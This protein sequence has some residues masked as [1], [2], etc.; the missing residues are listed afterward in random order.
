MKISILG[1]GI[2]GRAQSLNLRDSGHEILVGNIS[3][4]YK[5]KA[6]EDGF[7]I[8]NL[9]KA[10][11][12]AEVILVLLPDEIQDD[13]L[14]TKILPVIKKNACLVFAHGFWLTYNQLKIP[15]HI[16]LLMIAPRSPGEQI[17][18]L[19]LE[20]YGVPAYIDIAQDGSG[21][22]KKILNELIIGLGFDKGGTINLSHTMETEIDLM[23]E[24]SMAPIFFASVQSVFKE[25]VSKG[26]PPE[27]VCLELYYSGELG[28]V[29][30]M[31]GLDGLYKA[32]Q[33]NASPTCQ[34]GVASSISRVWRNH[35]DEIIKSQYE[36]IKSGKF[37][38]ELQKI[39][40]RKIISSFLNS[41]IAKKIQEAEISISQKIKKS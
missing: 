15:D 40:T 37:A 19:Y 10:V 8:V 14:K 7:N 2:Q 25:L 24:Q 21:N 26:Y 12:N 23:I 9:E 38:L 36:R 27:V 1:Y 35:M 28:S 18:S 39:D 5:N 30:K 17:R 32:F 29:R 41:K 11:L 4:K 20:G 3:D 33:N 13:I 22:A 6:I 16:D 31:M 34:Y